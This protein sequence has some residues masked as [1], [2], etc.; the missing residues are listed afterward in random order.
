ML[1]LD[2]ADMMRFKLEIRVWPT[3][4]IDCLHHCSSRYDSFASKGSRVE[5]RPMGIEGEE[6][7]PI[8]CHI[9]VDVSACS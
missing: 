8:A 4:S 2:V 5:N 9:L 7:D 1:G 6:V 3:A